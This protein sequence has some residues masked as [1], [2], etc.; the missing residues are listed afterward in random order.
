MNQ[1]NVPEVL[2]K[3]ADIA[4]LA[5]IRGQV[6]QEREQFVAGFNL[7]DGRSQM[8][9]VRVTN[10]TVGDS[11]VITFFSPCHVVESGFLK[12]ITKDMAVD[13]LQKN[14]QMLFA[15]YGLW[16]QGKTHMVVA[17][18]DQILD[19]LDPEEFNAHIWHVAFAA[20]IYEK[21]QGGGDRF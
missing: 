20:D 6:D 13:L 17:S 7:P 21:Q 14:E 3:V 8:V 1:P 9:Y 12:G 2:S 5:G 16:T 15:R 10:K 11:P 18:V 4:T 19:T